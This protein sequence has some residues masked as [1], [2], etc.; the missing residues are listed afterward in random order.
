MSPFLADIQSEAFA[1]R[2][3]SSHTL[4]AAV[5][6]LR[7]YLSL[8]SLHRASASLR[9]PCYAYHLAECIGRVG[10]SYPFPAVKLVVAAVSTVGGTVEAFH[11]DSYPYSCLHPF[12]PSRFLTSESLEV[13]IFVV[14]WAAAYVDSHASRVDRASPDLPYA[15]PYYLRHT[16]GLP[17]QTYD[18]SEVIVGEAGVVVEWGPSPFHRPLGQYRSFLGTVTGGER[19]QALSYLHSWAYQYLTGYEVTF[20][21]LAL[22]AS[23]IEGERSLVGFLAAPTLHGLS[24][25]ASLP[26]LQ[27]SVALPEV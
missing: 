5:A 4:Q 6:A 18:A 7:T 11:L 22:Q 2:A 21:G 15:L 8:H 10:A 9:C 25:S 13:W 27:A 14:E 1:V 20:A 17:Y 24:L 23:M 16:V 12:R 3:G 26:Q 19:P